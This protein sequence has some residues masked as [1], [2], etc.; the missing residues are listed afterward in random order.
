MHINEIPIGQ[1]LMLALLIILIGIGATATLKKAGASSKA[2]KIVFWGS[3]IVG[4]IVALAG[5]INGLFIHRV[6]YTWSLYPWKVATIIESVIVFLS[7]W[8]SIAVIMAPFALLLLL[9]ER[10]IEYVIGYGFDKLPK[11][12]SKISGWYRNL[13]K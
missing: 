7:G 3:A 4:A 13:T 2:R 11:M 10:V 5:G 9:C 1:I 8:V 6:P 12:A